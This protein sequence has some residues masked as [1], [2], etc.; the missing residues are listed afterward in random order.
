MSQGMGSREGTANSDAVGTEVHQPHDHLR[1]FLPEL[2][3][4]PI[5]FATRMAPELQRQLKARCA[6]HGIRI[7]DAV[8]SAIA[9]WLR[10]QSDPSGNSRPSR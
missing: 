7:Q 6:E 1:P 8:H 4:R 2:D 3:T 5:P 9:T 10:N